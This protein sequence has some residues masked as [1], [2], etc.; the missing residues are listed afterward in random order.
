[1]TDVCIKSLVGYSVEV[2][3]AVAMDGFF[4]YFSVGVWDYGVITIAH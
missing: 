4:D 2:V 3:I 1:L